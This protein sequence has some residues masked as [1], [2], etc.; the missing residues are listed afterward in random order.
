M[1]TI[2]SDLL[3]RLCDLKDRTQYAYD[4]T[5]HEYGAHTHSGYLDAQIGYRYTTSA[6]NDLV[7]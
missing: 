6:L 2:V 1:V 5:H 4:R 7:G 3:D